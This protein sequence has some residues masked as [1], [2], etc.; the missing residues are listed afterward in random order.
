MTKISNIVQINSGYTSYVDLYEDYYDLVK[1]RGRME[2]YKPI[3]AHRLAFEKIANALDPRDRRFYFLSGSYGTGK[4]HLLLMLANYFA[5]PSDVPE[6]VSFFNNYG[7]AQSEVLLRPGEELKEQRAAKLKDKRKSGCY[8]VALCRYSLNLDFEGA[9]LR[10]LEEALQ[11]DESNILFDS[12]YSEALR[13]I[14]KWE[15]QRNQT[16]FYTD[17]ETSL[18]KSYPDWTINGL[19]AGL[20]G[21]NEPALKIFKDCFK[22]VT[23]TDFSYNKD[24]L[25]DIISD[26]LKNPGFKER[27]KGIVFLYDEFGASIDANLVNYTTL[28]DFAQYCAESTLVTGGTVAFIGTGHKGF[29]NHGTVGDLNA[30]TLEARVTEIGLETQGM[31][32]IIAAIVQPKKDSPAWNQQ[33]QPKV[34]K[35]TWLSGECNQRKLFSWLPAPKI[36]N[37]IIQ[38]I[39]PMHPLATFALLR[40]AGEVGSANRSVF[41]FF[42]PEF[43]TGETG[44][45][46]AQPYSY[47][48]FLEKNEIINHNKLTLYTA[49]L[50][51]D[52]FQESLKAANNRLAERV[53]KAVIN[54]QTT[55]QKLNAYLAN[56]TQQ[57][58]FEET[59]EL[60]LRI[61]KVMLINE[62]VSS[63]GVTIVN[64]AQNIEFTLDFVSQEEKTQVE[65]RLSLLC[66]A[67]VIFDN[68]GVYEFLRSDRQD[69][70]QLIEQYK[71][72]PDNRPTN[73][74][75][76]FLKLAPLQGEEVYL[77]A[78]DYNSSYNED[79][80]LKVIFATPSMLVENR[81][82]N[83][84]S[85]SYFAVLEHQRSAVSSLVTGYEGIALYVFC[86]N[87]N[88]IDAAKRAVLQNDQG[89]VVVAFP[90]VP[91]AVYD[92]IITLDA[93]ESDWY[94]QQSQNFG[95]FEKAEERTIREEAKRALLEAKAMYFSNSKVHWFAKDGNEIT[96]PENIRHAAANQLMQIQYGSTRNTIPHNEF[97]KSHINITANVKA[98]FKE[99]GDILCDFS[100]PIQINWTWPENRGG[101][102]YLRKC[103]VDY[104]VL[105]VLRDEGSIR[106]LEAERDIDKFRTAMPAYA[107]LLKELK[108]LE[109]K[110]QINFQQFIKPFFEEYGQGEIA[111]TLMLLLA[112]RFYGDS[113]R[114]KR[115]T[116]HLE[117]IQFNATEDMLFLVQRQS[118]SAVLFFEP[119]S[120]E[121]RAYFAK[122]THIFSNQ[123]APADKVYTINEAFQAAVHWWDHLPMIA[124]SSDFYKEE[125]KPLMKIF[126][127]A[128]V[129]DPFHF[130]KYDLLEPLGQVPGETLTPLKITQIEIHLKAFKAAAE[131][132]Q[133]SVQEQILARTAELFGSSS[134]LD[135]DIQDALR[136]WHNELR[137]TEKDQMGTYHN[138]DSKPLVKF[139]AY[140]NIR[141]LLFKTLPEAYSLGSVETWT[142]KS[143]VDTFMQRIRN[144]KKHIE[145]N[146]PLP[147]QLKVDF[148]NDV[149]QDRNQVIYR[150]ELILH[151]DTEDGQG[152][153]YYTEDG[154]DPTSS[155]QRQKLTP[156][157]TLTIKGNRRVKLVVG[158]EKG[159]YSAVT[160]IEAI[161]E[162][163]KY[164]IAR[165][166]Q[167][168]FTDEPITF[169]FPENKGAAWITLSSF[170]EELAKSGIYS[171]S[172][173]RQA[174]LHALEKIEK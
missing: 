36:K 34:G 86:E 105:S 162:L 94:R 118:P 110:G 11:K 46:N 42:A 100:Q 62:I 66:G 52:Y 76:A 161:D 60:M 57:M 18:A 97:N 143:M 16:R 75:E 20:I 24:N 53:K 5:S 172:E 68:Q 73:L 152:T 64:N 15:E 25:R 136:H 9:L 146:A 112:R 61:L 101:T 50:L 27:Y 150:G 10:A 22:V 1:N 171:N 126:S 79:K 96:V 51:V 92:A 32:D 3:T 122:I 17:L 133:E 41:K 65:N 81:D 127:Q 93:I 149:S 165:S 69:V 55:L 130:I 103:F 72:N 48:W 138:N 159:N 132:V 109:G 82:I 160:T 154:S 37:N 148:T 135:V 134:H 113:L 129:K 90:R 30:E 70:R 59:D 115:E 91:I 169:V 167:S 89:R 141:E 111:V 120:A 131:A 102:K 151:A 87:D 71:A 98:I 107:S 78:K 170:V 26:F 63:Q 153:I 164:K 38:N 35:F 31:E 173:L 88:D 157:D 114:F 19:T 40:L 12:H 166:V 49:D 6:L 33:V 39:Y 2:R 54:Y 116:N 147:A 139:T 13:R 124:H 99:G 104:Q 85:M 156:G 43:Q 142:T 29:R 163:N 158:D 106:Y 74:L 77:E 4:S 145:T 80:R 168:G 140:T 121:D 47:P 128:K 117:D 23:D 14:K 119:V 125:E 58:L 123:P 155:Q 174:V 137:D 21:F 8:L 7:T 83:G 45:Q 95:A 56:K 44:Y 84:T 67:G 28:L 108:K 144:G